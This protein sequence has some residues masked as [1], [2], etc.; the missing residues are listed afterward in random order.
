MKQSL[1]HNKRK[2]D[3]PFGNMDDSS[4]SHKQNGM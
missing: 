4:F 2:G 1:L 3:F